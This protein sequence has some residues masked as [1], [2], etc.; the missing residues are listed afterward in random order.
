MYVGIV[1]YVLRSAKSSQINALMNRDDVEFNQKSVSYQNEGLTAQLKDA[2]ANK[3]ISIVT[4]TFLPAT[5]VAAICS[6]SVFDWQRKD[7]VGVSPHFWIFWVVA[8]TLTALV[9]GIFL[10]WK[11]RLHKKA[12]QR[13]R[14][15]EEEKARKEEESD[16]DSEIPDEPKHGVSRRQRDSKAQRQQN[17]PNGDEKQSHVYQQEEREEQIRS[18]R[19][20][21]RHR[22]HSR[23]S[24]TTSREGHAH[25]GFSRTA[26]GLSFRG[27]STIV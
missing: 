11:R 22:S 13:E 27:E 24:H 10:I 9:L 7:R 19:R 17:R 23:R 5:A 21:S 20:R 8:I 2:Q 25:P 12:R 14:D 15:E 4:M 6:M 1:F 18:S 3:A 26:S 16:D